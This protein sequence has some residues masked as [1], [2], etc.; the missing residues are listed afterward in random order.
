MHLA[1]AYSQAGRQEDAHKTAAE[2]LRLNPEFSVESYAKIYK[3]PAVRE[4]LIN[5]LHK[6]G[7]K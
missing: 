7:L 6:A 4:Q 1:A 2:F 3:D 5:A